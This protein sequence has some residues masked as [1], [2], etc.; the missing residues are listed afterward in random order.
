[1]L[2]RLKSGTSQKT[3]LSLTA[4][5]PEEISQLEE[6]SRMPPPSYEEAKQPRVFSVAEATRMSWEAWRDGH[7]T[8][9]RLC[10]TE[11]PFIKTCY[12]AYSTAICTKC[13]H[14]ACPMCTFSSAFQSL[15]TAMALSIVSI[16][17]DLFG[18][19]Y[20]LVCP[21]CGKSSGGGVIPPPIFQCAALNWAERKS[22]ELIGLNIPQR[23][24]R[25]IALCFKRR[26][27]TPL[28]ECSRPFS[29]YH[30]NALRQG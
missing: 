24:R 9:C 15:S 13:K 11:N 1:M 28:C 30:W 4:R 5:V 23:I 21:G 14:V 22:I 7:W 10:S 3:T 25:K 2:N 26:P 6:P 16:S 17:R 8:C 19:P 12:E 27:K 20:L 29:A 18:S